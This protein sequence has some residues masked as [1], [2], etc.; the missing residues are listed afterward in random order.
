MLVRW[1]HGT[2]EFHRGRTDGN[3]RVSHPPAERTVVLVDR[4][5]VRLLRLRSG[6]GNSRGGEGK[7]EAAAL[8]QATIACGGGQAQDGTHPQ[9]VSPHAAKLSIRG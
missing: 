1:E 7:V 4:R 5:D 9:A 2:R 3:S 6:G 8:G